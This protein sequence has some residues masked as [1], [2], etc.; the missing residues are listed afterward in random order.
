MLA[1]TATRSVPSHG[2]PEIT[3]AGILRQVTNIM[4]LGFI[5]HG[6]QPGLER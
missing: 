4:C 5:I 2:G 6:V 3:R 1:I